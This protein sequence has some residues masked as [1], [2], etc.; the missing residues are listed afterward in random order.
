[1]NEAPRQHKKLRTRKLIDKSLQLKLVGAFIAVGCV[2]T[3]FQVI[4]L[5]Q[6]ML[7][8]SADLGPE[9]DALLSATPS[10][11]TRGILVTL[12]LLVPALTLVGILTTHRIAGPAYRMR[13]YFQEIAKS[14]NVTYKCRIRKHDEL[15]GMC[16]LVNRAVERVQADA[17]PAN[18]AR[19]AA[20]QSDPLEEAP[21]VRP[22]KPRAP[23]P[24]KE[25]WQA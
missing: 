16:D 25:D 2:A 22:S 8:L 9:G 19:E 5:N 13:C 3:L 23:E 20:Q 18:P 10:I 21:A 12:G 24:Q 14:G 6:S 17:Q 15:Q 4:L 1:M 11:L 7:N